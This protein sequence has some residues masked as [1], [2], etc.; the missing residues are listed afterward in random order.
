MKKH[1][2]KAQLQL[3]T[4]GMMGFIGFV[5]IAVLT[6]L[7]VEIIGS[8]NTVCGGGVNETQT[9]Y[10]GVCYSCPYNSTTPMP[11]NTSSGYCTNSS[12]GAIKENT[13]KVFGSGANNATQNLKTA[14]MLPPQFASLIVIVVIIIG[15]LGLL[16][17]AGFQAYQK[18]K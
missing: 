5:L 14:A 6:V 10:N 11:Y 9:Y 7:M 3:I 17:F 4:T 18:M 1:N 12:N 13:A 16:A 2:K 8:T 15:I